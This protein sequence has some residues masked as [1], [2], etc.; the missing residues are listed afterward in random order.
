MA[1]LMKNLATMVYPMKGIPWVID[2][3]SANPVLIGK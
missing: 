1:G 2:E 3:R